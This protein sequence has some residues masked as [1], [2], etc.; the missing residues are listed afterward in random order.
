MISRQLRVHMSVA[1]SCVL[2]TPERNLPPRTF[3]TAL[4]PLIEHLGACAR[5]GPSDCFG[6]SAAIGAAFLQLKTELRA[7][8][9]L[10]P[11]M[12]PIA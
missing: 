12:E 8:G 6:S 5:M 2:S 10:Y 3:D 9:L 7:S 4:T 1:L 11:A